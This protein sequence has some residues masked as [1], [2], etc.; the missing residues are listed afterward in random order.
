MFA[1]F[2]KW[3]GKVDLNHRSVASK[4]TGDG[5]TPLLPEKN[6]GPEDLRS[7]GQKTADCSGLYGS[8]RGMRTPLVAGATCVLVSN[9]IPCCI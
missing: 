8:L 2:L 3:S 9:L 6:K 4:A 5:Q 7:R 1:P